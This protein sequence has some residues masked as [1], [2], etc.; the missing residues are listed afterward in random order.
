[1]ALTISVPFIDY[2]SLR[3]FSNAVIKDINHISENQSFSSSGLSTFPE[4][5][6]M[7]NYVNNGHLDE[8]TSS[9]QDDNFE[10]IFKS[11]LEYLGEYLKQIY[12]T[13]KN[14]WNEIF[15]SLFDILIK[16]LLNYTIE[17]KLLPVSSFEEI[18]QY[19]KI[20]GLKY[21]S[22]KTIN[23][24]AAGIQYNIINYNWITEKNLEELK[25][26]NHEVDEKYQNAFKNLVNLWNISKNEKEFAEKMN[27]EL[28][29]IIET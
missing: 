22:Y 6:I 4:L 21:I 28:N 11:F 3:K 29:Q 19:A 14:G 26:F 15:P 13:L 7:P 27:Q 5:N 1:M 24:L 12:N 8:I 17:E 20:F 16:Y 25:E 9:P 23:R 2:N 10:D 18:F